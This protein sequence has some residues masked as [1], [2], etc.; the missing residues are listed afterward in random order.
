MCS[1][2]VFITSFINAKSNDIDNPYYFETKLKRKK[3]SCEIRG[4]K[5][6]NHGA[7]NKTISHAGLRKHKCQ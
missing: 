3:C 4:G 2:S 6:I 7:F 1:N 5:F